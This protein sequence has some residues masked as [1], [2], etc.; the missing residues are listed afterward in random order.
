[1]A[2]ARPIRDDDWNFLKVQSVHGSHLLLRE[3]LAIRL[4]DAKSGKA[5]V[6]KGQERDPYTREIYFVV[7]GYWEDSAGHARVAIVTDDRGSELKEV[8]IFD[9]GPAESTPSLR[10]ANKT[11]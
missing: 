6:L 9:L 2:C 5:V 1:L 7:A 4:L 10:S 3:A 8:E 11:G